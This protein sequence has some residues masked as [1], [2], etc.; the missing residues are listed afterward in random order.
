MHC[1]LQCRMRRIAAAFTIFLGVSGGARPTADNIPLTRAVAFDG[2]A[3]ELPRDLPGTA[4]V[5]VLGFTRSSEGATTV[6]GTKVRRELVRPPAIDA[7][8]MPMLAEIP[9]F[10]RGLVIRSIRHKV[11]DIERPNFVPLTS[12]EDA[13]KQLAGFVP[14]ASDAAYVL[15]VDRKGAVRWRTHAEC[16]AETFAQ[17]SAEA[18]KV[19]GP[20][21]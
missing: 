9:A 15:L 2:H 21:Q 11:P 8:A 20:P 3:V 12:D 10:L 16:T 18:Q 1:M 13:W 6:W 4:T 17:L 14:D 19:A 5:L 7:F